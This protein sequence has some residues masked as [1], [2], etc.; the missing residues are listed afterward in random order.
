MTEYVAER[1]GERLDRFLARACPEVSR[2]RWQSWIKRGLVRVGGE[3]ER[4]WDRKMH[5]GE[6]VRAEPPEVSEADGLVPVEGELKVL[7]EDGDLLA[8]DKPAGLV[9][10]PGPGHESD[11]LVNVVLWACGDLKGV[12]DERRPGI[13]H[14]LDRDT[15]GVMVVAKSEAGY[16]GLAMQF[17][18]HTLVKEYAALCWGRFERTSGVEEGAIG[19]DPRNRKKMA[20][21][22]EGGRAAL[23][24]W[25]VVAQG[26]AAAEL[27]VRIETGRTHQ[28]RVHM[29]AAGHPVCGDALYGRK[30]TTADGW[31]P[32]RQMLHAARLEL[33]HPVTGEPMELCAPV[34]ADFAE[35]REKLLETAAGTDGA[36]A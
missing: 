33:K 11:T 13:V 10:H 30:R 1:E 32:A 12:G 19:R 15:S 4:A 7:Y 22:A 6:V 24:R 25:R 34:P 3:E 27:R 29:A 31:A 23:S 2:T 9:V 8:I 28:I 18:A 5:A 36:G 17:A 35:A 21:V 16:R 26:A 20:I 14:R